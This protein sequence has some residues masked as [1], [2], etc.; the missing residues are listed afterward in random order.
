MGLATAQ[1][2]QDHEDLEADIDNQIDM[3]LETE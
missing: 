1:G 2:D 3:N